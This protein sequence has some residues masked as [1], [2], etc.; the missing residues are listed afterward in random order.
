MVAHPFNPRT[1]VV[2]AGRSLEFEA[3]L[4]CRVSLCRPDWLGMQMCRAASL[5]LR[6]LSASAF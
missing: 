3:I 1:W 5:E 6:D 2:K 4:V